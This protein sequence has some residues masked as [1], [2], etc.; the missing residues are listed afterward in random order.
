MIPNLPVDLADL[1]WRSP[2]EADLGGWAA[3]IARTAAVEKP[4]WFERTAELHQIMESSKNPP[5]SSIVLGF[6]A[7][8]VPRAYARTFKNRDGEK[9]YGFG[10]VDPEWQRRG[11]G[12][13]LLGWLEERTRQRFAQ[14]NACNIAGG[15]GRV[16]R[17]RI[18]MEQQHGHQAGLF[19][20]SGYSIVRYFNE[21][22]RPLDLPLPDVVLD[23]GLELVAMSPGISEAVRQ[24]HN[25]AFRDHWGSEPRDEESWGFTVHDPQARPDLS[26]VVVD[27]ATGAVA[28]CQ[29]ASHDRESSVSRGFL[30]GYTEQLGVRRE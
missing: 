29:L 7:T 2:T 12:T 3:L 11:V 25:D 23:H 22:H 14:D 5:A 21:M 6:D 24:A 28:G 27:P 9:A 4:V 18:H 26:G 8:G 20:K 15:D 16:P 30:E 13:A 17:L 10:C 19:R 1:G